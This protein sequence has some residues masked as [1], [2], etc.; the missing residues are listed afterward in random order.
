MYVQHHTLRVGIRRGNNFRCPTVSGDVPI[1]DILRDWRI[2]AAER[3][4]D[5]SLRFEWR[6]RRERRIVGQILENS[7]VVTIRTS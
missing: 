6:I 7:V 4:N 3:V 2:Q 1:D 5:A